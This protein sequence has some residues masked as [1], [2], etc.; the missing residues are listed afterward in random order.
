MAQ[1]KEKAKEIALSSSIL[2]LPNVISKKNIFFKILWL[3][4]FLGSA[5][6]GIVSVQKTISSYLKYEVVTKIDVINEIP[7]IFPASKKL[8]RIKFKFK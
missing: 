6:V 4:A 8:F 3:V 7:T 2:G 5:S 1:I